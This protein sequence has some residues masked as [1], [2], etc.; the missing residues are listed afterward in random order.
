[1]TVEEVFL[2]RLPRFLRSAKLLERLRE[3]EDEYLKTST[4]G[5]LVIEANFRSGEHKTT[6]IRRE[7]THS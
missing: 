7:E 5:P 1:M 2:S 4:T 3:A 6:K